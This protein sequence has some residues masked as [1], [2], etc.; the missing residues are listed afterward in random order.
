MS[1][2]ASWTPDYAKENSSA[3]LLNVCI[4]FA[5]IE[6]FFIIALIASWHLNNHTKYN[7]KPA[8][9]LI[10][11]GYACCIGGVAIGICKWTIFSSI[12]VLGIYRIS[13]QITL[14]GAGYHAVTLTPSTLT[15]MFK[16]AKAH[17]FVYLSSILFPKLAILYL[18]LRLF[19]SKKIHYII[20]ATIVLVIGT[21]LFGIVASAANCRPFSAYWNHAIEEHCTIDRMSLFR[22]YSIPNLASDALLL[23][24]PIP[25]VSKVHVGMSSKI[26]LYLT[27]LVI[28]L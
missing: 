6:T 9:Y 28:A 18:Y 5:I 19:I 21:Y 22:Y 20:Y 12:T 25:A 27:F 24:V 3:P 23:V 17:E 13:V 10:L 4:S 8:L 11:I 26:G 14:G 7:W 15:L 1:K 16:L 2:P